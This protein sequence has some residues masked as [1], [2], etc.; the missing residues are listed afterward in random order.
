MPFDSTPVDRSPPQASA[1]HPNG[2]IIAACFYFNERDFFFL[3]E[4]ENIKKYIL[5]S[6]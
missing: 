4:H 6:S 1:V 5:V 3:D 2:R